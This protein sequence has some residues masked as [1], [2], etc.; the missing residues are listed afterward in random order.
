MPLD[1]HRARDHARRLVGGADPKTVADRLS[2]RPGA[3]MVN[4]G[5]SAVTPAALARRWRAV[6]G[7]RDAL[8]P[9]HPPAAYAANLEHLLGAVEV[10]LGLAGPLRVNGLHAHGDF[11]LPLATHEA[12]LVAGIHRGCQLISAAGGCSALLLAEGVTRAPGF[13]FASCAEA[14]RFTAWVLEQEDH[15]R[16]VA[17]G[18]T[19]HGRLDSLRVTIEGSHVHLLLDFTT[20]DAAGQNLVTIATQAVCAD[21]VARSPVTPHHWYIEANA[22]GDKKASALSFGGVRGRKVTAEVLLPADLVQ[23]RLHATPVQLARYGLM[24]GIGGV[25]AGT[26][27]IQAHA[28]NALAAL[29]IATGQDAACVAEAAVGITRVELRDDGA[30]YAAVTLPNLIVGTVGGG[31]GLPS[32]RACLELMGLAGDGHARA[33]AEVCAGAVLAGELSIMGAIASGEFTQA[34]ERLAR[35]RRDRLHPKPGVSPR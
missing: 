23:E 6:G 21:L 29:F 25:I 19:S 1:L 2:P 26:L 31:T 22:S 20:G 24:A 12:A 14:G 5:G 27:G 34:H 28:A 35:R 18:T 30:L 10:P 4:L 13:A 3:P 9:R 7:E 32:Q 17:A 16:T 11:W 8:T 33:L 15:L